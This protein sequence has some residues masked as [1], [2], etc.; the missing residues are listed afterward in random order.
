MSFLN[1][2][3]WR[4][5]TKK[6]D[7]TRF[8]SV[9]D[10][11]KI[12]DAIRMAPSSFGLQPFHVKVVTDH[13]VRQELR[14][15]AWDQQQITDAS[16]LLVFCARTDLSKRVDDYI[17]VMSGGDGGKKG[18][19]TS[20]KDMVLGSVSEMTEDEAL[21]WASKQTY[22]ALGFGLAACSELEIDSCPMEGF[23]PE[24]YAKILALPSNLVPTALCPIGYA[25]DTQ[26]HKIRF[27]EEDIFI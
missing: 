6:F 8:V 26:N 19:F 22:I 2:L 16:F 11:E 15:K 7:S 20:Y 14:T 27:K 13:S 12:F 23:N 1:K 21:S 5:A 18:S 4:Y 3:D 9:E 24:A 25:S 17:D 10:K